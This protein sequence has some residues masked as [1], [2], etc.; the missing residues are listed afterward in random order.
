MRRKMRMIIK[1]H[2][3]KK[4]KNKNANKN[5]NENNKGRMATQKIR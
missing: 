3:N 5:E 2:E 1:K 4:E